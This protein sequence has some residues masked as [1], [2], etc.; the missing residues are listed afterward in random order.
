MGNR[1]IKDESHNYKLF[2]ETNNNHDT[3]SLNGKKLKTKEFESPNS[4][5]KY[6]RESRDLVDIYGMD[7]PEY[8][9]ISDKYHGDLSFKFE[10][11][12][13]AN[14]DIEVEIGKG[15]PVPHLAEQAI[16]SIS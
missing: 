4:L 8:Q 15:F 2:I 13:I 1:Y 14:V 7:K 5:S 3:V 12:V 11:L 10:N 6:I 9:F 16:N